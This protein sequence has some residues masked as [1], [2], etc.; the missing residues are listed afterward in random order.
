MNPLEDIST[1]ID[2]ILKI[3]GHSA[4]ETIEYRNKLLD[5]IMENAISLLIM[6]VPDKQTL[7]ASLDKDPSLSGRLAVLLENF[8]EEEV[9]NTFQLASSGVMGDYFKTIMD[10]L[11]SKQRQAIKVVITK[12][13]ETV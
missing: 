10:S 12:S 1:L 3:V 6:Q 7:Y 2:S 11:T 13:M 9:S 5:T 8:S 4:E